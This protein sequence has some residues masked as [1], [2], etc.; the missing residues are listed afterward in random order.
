MTKC[1]E[2]RI[3]NP[4][5]FIAKKLTEQHKMNK[6]QKPIDCQQPQPQLLSKVKKEQ[7]QEIPQIKA[8]VC[9]AKCKEDQLVT[10]TKTLSIEENR[11]ATR[12]RFKDEFEESFDGSAEPKVRKMIK[13]KKLPGEISTILL[14][15]S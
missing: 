11:S 6:N 13:K 5:K 14:S 8:E 12:K 4:K 7:Q 3:E 1:F 10:I 15:D 2:K 9:D